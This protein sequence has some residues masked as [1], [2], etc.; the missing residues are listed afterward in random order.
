[1]RDADRKSTAEI[2]MEI[3]R[4]AERAR[5]GE[6][7]LSDMEGGTFSITN[8]GGIGGAW[9]TPIIR[10]PEVAILGVARAR[11]ELYRH[12]DGI[13]ERLCLPLSL[14]YDHRVINGAD[15]ARF[16]R[17]LAE[18]LEEPLNLLMEC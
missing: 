16:T 12:G 9:F 10:A 8:V 5:A 7:E 11:S 4:L 2:A 17:D 13:D 6:L 1:V 14:S 15:A 3:D 18:L